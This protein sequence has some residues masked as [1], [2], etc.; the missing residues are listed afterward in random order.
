[1]TPILADPEKMM[2]GAAVRIQS[3]ARG[4]LDRHRVDSI[5][6]KREEKMQEMYE[7]TDVVRED[8]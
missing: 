3:L 4:K 5:K 1:M 7:H 6:N 2:E 8:R